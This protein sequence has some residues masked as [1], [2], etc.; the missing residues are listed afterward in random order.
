MSDATMS[1]VIGKD[2]KCLGQIQK[3][4]QDSPDCKAFGGRLL[5]ESS[6]MMVAVIGRHR[7]LNAGI[8]LGSPLN[9]SP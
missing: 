2:S 1:N 9:P 8:F 3:R 7:R 4:D 6:C 5:L